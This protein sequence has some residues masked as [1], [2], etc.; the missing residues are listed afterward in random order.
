[1]VQRGIVSRGI[2]GRY[3][4]G[5]GDSQAADALAGQIVEAEVARV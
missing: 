1:M 2:S 5:S 4:K 3:A